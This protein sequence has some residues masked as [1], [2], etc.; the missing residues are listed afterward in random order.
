MDNSTELKMDTSTELRMESESPSSELENLQSGNTSDNDTMESGKNGNY[1]VNPEVDDNIKIDV[2]SEKEDGDTG[3]TDGNVNE[4][5]SQAMFIDLQE[6]ITKKLKSDRRLT[7]SVLLE[8]H[9]SDGSSKLNES[10]G[11]RPSSA[12]SSGKSGTPGKDRGGNCIYL[13]C[14]FC[15]F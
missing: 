3:N 11:S 14:E 13:L 10:L 6:P 9:S 8:K 4:S 15:I 12:A 7:D 5:K 2:T 1:D